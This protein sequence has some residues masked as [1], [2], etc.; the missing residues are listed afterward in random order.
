LRYAKVRELLS[1]IAKDTQLPL[2]TVE[3]AL[4]RLTVPV[5]G[6][7]KNWQDYGGELKKGLDMPSTQTTDDDGTPDDEDDVPPQA[8]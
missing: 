2:V 6:K 3:R 4:Y 1:G 7:G 8:P 5:T